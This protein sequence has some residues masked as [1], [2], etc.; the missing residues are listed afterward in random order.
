M[1]AMPIRQAEGQDADGLATVHV[2]SWQHAY[3]GLV[4][5]A[6]LDALSIEKH[7]A[8]WRKALLAGDPR[9]SV[10]LQQNSVAGFV[11]RGQTRDDDLG[12]DAS[13][14]GAIYV[15]PEY[16]HQGIGRSLWERAC[17]DAKEHCAGR[18]SAW[19]FEQN[20]E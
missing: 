12:A 13:E 5:Q 20:P 7:A 16:W 1:T 3:A 18:I 17:Q 2:R 10:A 6:H 11:T 19:V 9:V 15:S 4:P 8:S 14:V